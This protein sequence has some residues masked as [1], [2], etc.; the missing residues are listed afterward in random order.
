[1]NYKKNIRNLSISIAP[2]GKEMLLAILTSLI[3]QAAILGVTAMTAYL[4]GLGLDRRLPQHVSGYLGGIAAL[5]LLRALM[6]WCEMYFAHDVAFRVI[7]NYRI[8]LFH[9]I[10]KIAPA[11]TLRRKTGELGQS[12]ISDVEILELFLAHTFSGFIVAVV[13]TLF[14]F[15]ALLYIDPLF[16]L[17]LLLAA[18]FF[19]PS[20]LP[21]KEPGR[22][23]GRRGKEKALRQQLFSS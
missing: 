8:E 5:I 13:M 16:S 11:Y 4:V 7:R 10:S 12:L 23:A 19:G 3:K 21:L 17:L 9:Q 2:Y 22:K 18:F 1:M 6:G 15:L 20:A 14:I